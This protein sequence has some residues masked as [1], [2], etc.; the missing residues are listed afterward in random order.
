[1]AASYQRDLL[2]PLAHEGP[3]AHVARLFLAPDQTRARV[4][5]QDF[6]ERVCR[7]GVELFEPQQVHVASPKLLPLL[8]QVV[9]DLAAAQDQLPRLLG[10]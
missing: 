1:M 8:Q 6:G 5:R 7:E 10:R 2:D 9:V 3:G 4:T